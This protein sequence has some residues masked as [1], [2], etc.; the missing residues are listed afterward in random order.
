MD[1]NILTAP[2]YKFALTEELL[3]ACE[4]KGEDPN[5]FLPVRAESRASGWDVRCANPDGINLRPNDYMKLSL[6]FRT[7]CPRGWWLELNPRSSTFIKKHIHSLYGK[8]D[9]SYQG[10]MMFCGQYIPDRK[11][12]VSTMAPQRIE[13]GDRIAQIMPIKL[14]LMNVES[15][16]NEEYDS[17]CKERNLSRGAGGFGSTGNL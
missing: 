1:E 9:E 5:K 4:E 7:F 17:L 13:F 15:V 14:K 12:L 10:E 16:T 8:I 2:N 6:G 3:K 11:K